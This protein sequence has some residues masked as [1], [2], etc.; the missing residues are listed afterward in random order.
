MIKGHR[1]VFA[2]NFRLHEPIIIPKMLKQMGFF[3]FLGFGTKF[4]YFNS[5]LFAVCRAI[6]K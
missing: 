3:S 2:D 6:R 5:E 4:K 1:S